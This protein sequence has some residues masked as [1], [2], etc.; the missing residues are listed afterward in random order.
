MN[1]NHM[2][3]N[4]LR[5]IP[6]IGCAF[7]CGVLLLILWGVLFLLYEFKWHILLAIA[8]FLIAKITY[9]SFGTKSKYMKYL[10]IILYLLIYVFFTI[11]YL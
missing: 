6:R 10:F 4:R 7:G 1:K 3:F 2:Y 9:D 8:L 11:R 5:K